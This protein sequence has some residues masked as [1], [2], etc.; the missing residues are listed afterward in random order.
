MSGEESKSAAVQGPPHSWVHLL[1]GLA[2]LMVA[3]VVCAALIAQFLA[4]RPLNMTALCAELAGSVESILTT[5]QIPRS[6]ITATPGEL[7]QDEGAQ[8]RHYEFLVEVPEALSASGIAALLEKGMALRNVSTRRDG[9][10]AGTP[11]TLSLALSGRE[12]ATVMFSGVPCLTM[13]LRHAEELPNVEL[14]AFP[15]LALAP[16]NPETPGDAQAGP[17]ESEESDAP[18]QQDAEGGE[19]L[20]SGAKAA[21]IVDDG[22][23]D[24]AVD[25][26]FLAMDNSLTLAILPGERFSAA[27]AARAADLGFE[28]MVHMPMESDT[29]RWAEPG[30]VCAKMNP[31]EIRKC[32]EDAIEKVPGAVGM[33]NHTGSVFTSNKTAMKSLLTVLGEHGFYFIDSRTTA[34]SVAFNTAQEMNVPSASRN[35]FLDNESGLAYIRGQCE[36]LMAAAKKEGTAVGIC[37]FRETTAAA[38]AKI[39]REFKK[40][41]VEIVHASEVVQ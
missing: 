15:A 18:V 41:G 19:A 1:S 12:F 7:R 28:V 11:E 6:G 31:D 36:E 25:A 2:A 32:V 30:Q 39:I 38:L 34:E 21:I 23:Q 22:G 16:M 13:H 37:H 5:N 24:E 8:W 26:A 4:S 29:K 17:S 20:P 9:G 40:A 14:P 33:N 27:T 35:V 10:T 3:A